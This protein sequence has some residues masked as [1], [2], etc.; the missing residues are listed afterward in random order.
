MTVHFDANEAEF[1]DSLSYEFQHAPP[2]TRRVDEG[3]SEEPIWMTGND[4]RHLP[5][6]DRIIGME[7]G[8]KDSLVN[9]GLRRTTEI[10]FQRRRGIPGT[11]QSVALASVAV[12]VD[13]HVRLSSDCI[14]APGLSPHGM[15]MV[16]VLGLPC[17]HLGQKLDAGLDAFEEVGQMELLVRPMYAII[18]QTK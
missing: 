4:P 11:G 17:P 3:K 7:R 14:D 5:V 13:D 6:R 15:G 8:Q 18:W 1:L 12:T 2:I 9:S 10:F 16:Q